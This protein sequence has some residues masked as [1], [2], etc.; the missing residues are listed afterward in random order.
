MPRFVFAFDDDE[1]DRRT[2]CCANREKNKCIEDWISFPSEMRMIIEKDDAEKF[3]KFLRK[4]K[5]V[6]H[7]NDGMLKYAG[8]EMCPHGILGKICHHRAYKCATLLLSRRRKV[9]SLMKL[10]LINCYGSYPI[11]DA[12]ISLSASLVKLFLDHG[13][14][15]DAWSLDQASISPLEYAVESLSCDRNLNSWSPG[16]S[17]FKLIITPCLPHMREALKTI[18]LLSGVSSNSLVVQNTIFSVVKRGQVVPVAVLLLLAQDR[19]MQTVYNHITDGRYLLFSEAIVNELAALISQESALLGSEEHSEILQLCREKKELMIYILQMIE[20]FDRAGPALKTYLKER[21]SD[22]TNEQVSC[23]VAELLEGAGFILSTDDRDMS[24]ITSS[25][26]PDLMPLEATLKQHGYDEED[27]PK[28]NFFKPCR[29]QLC[30]C[31]M[32]MP[33]CTTSTVFQRIVGT[34]L[35]SHHRGFSSRAGPSIKTLLNSAERGGLN[36]FDVKNQFSVE[37]TDGSSEGS[38]ATDEF[39]VSTRPTQY[40]KN[41]LLYVEPSKF[42]PAGVFNSLMPLGY[43]DRLKY[44]DGL[45]IRSCNVLRETIFRVLDGRKIEELTLEESLCFKHRLESRLEIKFK[46]AETLT[47]KENKGPKQLAIEKKGSTPGSILPHTLTTALKPGVSYPLSEAFKHLDVKKIPSSV[48]SA[49]KKG[50]CFV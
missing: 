15:L 25:A 24:D 13:A 49:I 16:K 50:K 29:E 44:Y 17:L 34:S 7:R 28:G 2:H 48:F 36:G 42:Q 4:S 30:R 8:F 11:H 19:V 33:S 31:D 9:G 43:N 32:R 22:V 46:E 27:D 14:S 26:K 40:L 21:T 1:D 6:F 20:I 35:Y 45:D 47:A 5:I 10:N 41:S 3:D 39:K 37:L 18:E 23:H 12:A 38:Q